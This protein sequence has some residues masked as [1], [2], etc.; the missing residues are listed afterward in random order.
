MS[1]LEANIAVTLTGYVMILIYYLAKLIPMLRAG[2]LVDKEVFTLWA[3]VIVA[4]IVLTILG[5]ILTTITLTIL[6]A[7]RT[8]SDTPP[9]LIEDER[10]KLIHLRGDRVAY[11]VSGIVV[12]GAMLSYVL[13]Q[14]ALVM[15][16]LLILAGILSE[17]CG[18][19]AR[20]IYYRKGV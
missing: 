9:R 14:P 20:L 3:V 2:E 8:Q 10:D 5:T 7:I 1:Y 19:I 6:N 18:Y 12:F 11:V 4:T 16:S 15:F 13:K 17:I